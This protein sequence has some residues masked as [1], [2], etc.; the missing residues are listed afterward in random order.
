[1]AVVR[2]AVGSV[3]LVL[4]NCCEEAVD[5]MPPYVG[6]EAG[7]LPEG[8]KL[9]RVLCFSNGLNIEESPTARRNELHTSITFTVCWPSHIAG[10]E[11]TGV[12]TARLEN[13]SLTVEGGFLPNSVAVY[14]CDVSNN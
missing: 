2:R 11:E 4:F 6:L 8:L 13:K 12:S 14:T 5:R 3:G 7:L 10:A 1:M 9:Q